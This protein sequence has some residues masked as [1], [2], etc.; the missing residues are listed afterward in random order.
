ML[1]L[2]GQEGLSASLEELGAQ[3]AAQ[4]LR[5]PR[6]KKLTEVR[7]AKEQEQPEVAVPQQALE[8]SEDLPEGLWVHEL[9]EILGERCCRPAK[10]SNKRRRVGPRDSYQQEYLIRGLFLEDDGDEGEADEEEVAEPNTYWVTEA[11]L[12][13]TIHC[14][15]DP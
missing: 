3:C 11:D 13:Q 7:K 6:C 12:L 2:Q 10:L 5:A 1:Q 15:P 9:T 4:L 8:D 14:K